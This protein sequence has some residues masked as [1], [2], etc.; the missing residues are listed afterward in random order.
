M[1]VLV[2]CSFSISFAVDVKEA[3]AGDEI[4]SEQ[5]A[6]ETPAKEDNDVATSSEEDLVAIAEEPQPEPEPEPQ[7]QPA[8]D[9][10]GLIAY[11]GY[12]SITLRWN[13]DPEAVSYKVERSDD[14]INFETVSSSITNA[15]NTLAE[16]PNLINFRDKRAKGKNVEYTYRVYAV[17]AVGPSV[18]PATAKEKCVRPMYEKV[19]FK[20]SAKLTSH[21]GKKKTHVFKRNQTVTAE[22]FGGGKYKFYYNGNLYF[23]TYTRMK[24]AKADF[25]KNPGGAVKKD[26]ESWRNKTHYYDQVTAENFVNESGQKS[27]TKYLIWVSTYTQHLY[28]FKG[29]KGNWKLIKD[30]EVSTGKAA[31]PTPSGFNKKLVK[32]IRRYSGIN[33][34]WNFQSMNSIHGKRSSYKIGAPASHGCVRN[35]DS[36]AKWIFTKCKKG[37]GLIVF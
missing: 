14:G 35:F 20:A 9:V 2:L 11:P 12:N 32:Q 19:T 1:T 21:D 36:N 7:P 31:S 22:G 34:W 8:A 23:A 30:W 28:I 24:N 10:T 17:N 18:N 15:A 26:S 3:P 27:K 33:Y 4:S 13:K 6:P 25:I 37:T 16:N 29:K 5:S